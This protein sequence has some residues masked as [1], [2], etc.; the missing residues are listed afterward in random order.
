MLSGCSQRSRDFLDQSSMKL[1]IHLSTYERIQEINLKK[2]N[3]SIFRLWCAEHVIELMVQIMCFYQPAEDQA[4]N[5]L[6][7]SSAWKSFQPI[8][9]ATAHEWHASSQRPDTTGI[10]THSG[11][12]GQHLDRQIPNFRKKRG[13]GGG[14]PTLGIF[15]CS[16]FRHVRLRWSHR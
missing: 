10:Q 3:G 16:I 1:V 8:L 4:L 12:T 6:S 15:D 13:V 9:A 5:H 14:R 2:Q 11:A 7:R